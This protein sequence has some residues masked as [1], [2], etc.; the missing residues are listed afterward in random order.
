MI[1]IGI[2]SIQ[3]SRDIL[4]NNPWYLQGQRERHAVGRNGTAPFRKAETASPIKARRV[5][6]ASKV[7]TY[8]MGTI[9][10]RLLNYNNSPSCRSSEILKK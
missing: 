7:R 9:L 4:G 5:I 3:H 6:V 1:Y 2:L 8:G 10:K